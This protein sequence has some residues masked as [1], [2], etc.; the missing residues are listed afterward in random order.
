MFGEYRYGDGKPRSFFASLYV[1]VEIQW[2]LKR[3]M[4]VCSEK[5]EGWIAK[6]G[7]IEVLDPKE[8]SL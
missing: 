1:G 4:D 6:R 8:V 2:T 5:E 7:R 3:M